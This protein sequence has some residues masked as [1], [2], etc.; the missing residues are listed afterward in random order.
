MTLEQYKERLHKAEENVAKRE[1]TIERHKSQLEKR[2]KKIQR[3]SWI[4]TN[5]LD[6]YRYDEDSRNRY[7]QETGSDLY[8]DICDVDDKLEDI[9]ASYE[10]LSELQRTVSNWK[11]KVAHAEMVTSVFE[12]DIP[13]SLKSYKTYL[14]EQWDAWDIV[15]RNTL[16]QEYKELGYKEFM[17]KHKTHAEYV[18]KDLTDEE[19]HRDNEREATNL[20]LDLYQRIFKYSGK[21]VSWEQLNIKAG[22]INGYITG[23]NAK[24]RVESI[25]AGGY[26]IQRLHV[27]V[28]VH[29]C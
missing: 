6:S 13:E 16:A 12:R 24:V 7:R 1:A 22:H 8:W 4:D 17:N 19:I 25:L 2:I 28:L 27:R 3:V 26:N 29:P 15:R 9:K 21:V 20:I 10:K 14:V 18:F 23:E 11:D 5:K